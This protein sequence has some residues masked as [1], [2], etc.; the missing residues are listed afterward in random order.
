MTNMNEILFV[1]I[2]IL[3]KHD[4]EKE[5]AFLPKHMG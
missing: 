3:R 1:V 5:L 2:K 4:V